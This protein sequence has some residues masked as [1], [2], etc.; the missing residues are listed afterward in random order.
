MTKTLSAV[1]DATTRAVGNLLG[2]LIGAIVLITLAAVWWRYVINDPLSWTE[3]ISRILFVWVTFLGA[4]VLYREKSHITID[5]FLDMMPETLKS[6]MV[7]LIEIG[8][9]LFIVVL[10]IYGL[11]LSLDTLPQRFGALDISPASF[12]FA[13]PV[14]AA[15]MMLFFIERLVDPSKRGPG[16][17][18]T[19]L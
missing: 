15:L 18:T 10:F 14:S 6:A 1:C 16:H 5:M 17:S 3:Q 13:A 19:I 7:W 2:L 8:V 9:L 4:A 11:K 12:Y